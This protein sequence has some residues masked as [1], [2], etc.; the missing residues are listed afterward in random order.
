MAL[1][2]LCFA[3]EAK[4]IFNFF[5][6]HLEFK[7]VAC[8]VHGYK[9]THFLALSCLGDICWDVA[10]YQA[11]CLKKAAPFS[12]LAAWVLCSREWRTCLRLYAH[13]HTERHYVRCTMTILAPTPPILPLSWGWQP[14]INLPR[15]ISCIPLDEFL[16]SVTNFHRMPCHKKA[17]SIFMFAWIL[18]HIGVGVSRVA[19]LYAYDTTGTYHE[20]LGSASSNPPLKHAPSSLFGTQHSIA[21]E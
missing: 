18:C 12:C 16:A 15:T 3:T 5:S 8:N 19:E 17:A 14:Q 2:C 20:D 13:M 6:D 1:P 11:A 21:I 4:S 9:Q 10:S 7:P